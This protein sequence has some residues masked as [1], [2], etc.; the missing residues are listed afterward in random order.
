[1]L[2]RTIAGLVKINATTYTG[3]RGLLPYSL[4]FSKLNQWYALKT[5][6]IVGSV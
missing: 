5:C 6:N 2:I 4:K 3:S 1:M